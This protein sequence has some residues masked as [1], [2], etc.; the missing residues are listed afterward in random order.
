M[1]PAALPLAK[2]VLHQI[3][4]EPE[5]FSMASFFGR[6]GTTAC[7]AGW[8]LILS[9]EFERNERGYLDYEGYTGIH[10][11]RLLGLPTEEAGTLFYLPN[12]KDAIARLRELISEVEMETPWPGYCQSCSAPLTPPDATS[13]RAC[14]ADDIDD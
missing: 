14:G 11:A 3:T 13:C 6:C 12:K 1:D 8:A 7:I 4:S 10:G 2:K 5:T 9:G